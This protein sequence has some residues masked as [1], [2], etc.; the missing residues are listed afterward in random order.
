[1]TDELHLGDFTSNAFSS[2]NIPKY[3]GETLVK[4]AREK[5]E[6]VVLSGDLTP[7]T[8]C[9]LF[10]DNFPNR[11]FNTGIAEANMIGV[12]AGMAR[13]GD[14]PFVHSFSVFL[15]R[16]ALDQI[17]MQI[18]YPNLNVKLCGFLP[19]LT[20]LLGVS[21]QAIED[22]SV[23]RSLPNMAIIEP[24]GARQIESAVRA[25]ANYKGP[26]Y[27]R[28]HRPSTALT[29]KDSL[30]PLEI[31]KG[32]LL[33]KGNDAI[34]F[35]MGHMVQEALT[36]SEELSRKGVKVAV[37]NIHT[38]KPLDIDF[39]IKHSRQVSA[40]ITAENHSIIGGLGS[41]VA[42]TLLEGN[43]SRKF[44]RIGIEDTFAEGG[45]T[46]FL[47]KKYGLTS[48]KIIDELEKLLD[49]Y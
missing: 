40:I 4:L 46:N 2:A 34:I 28:M 26:V 20:T 16:R 47:F 39:I 45:S 32:Q 14:I 3:Y 9:D 17:A 7:A 6:I 33:V 48:T 12:S 10:R 49:S 5:A 24:C 36:A 13:S 15:N 38:L 19:G 25:A 29:T 18:A 35:A 42:E 8:E 41:A 23:M 11:F 30:L 37:A 44:K 21:H 27:L 1:M 43:V 22:N 31:G